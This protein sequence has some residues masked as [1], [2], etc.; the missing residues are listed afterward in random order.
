MYFIYTNYLKK[1]I[2]LKTAAKYPI[3]LIPPK[4][5]ITLSFFQ[6]Y[7]FKSSNILYS[8]N[9]GIVTEMI[10]PDEPPVNDRILE[11][12]LL[13]TENKIK[14][15]TKRTVIIIFLTVDISGLLNIKIDKYILLIY[16]CSNKDE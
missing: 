14:T 13:N 7:Q 16:N 15:E 3:K 8:I 2:V 11:I 6:W 12:S 5:N 1:S 4:N 9:P 10:T